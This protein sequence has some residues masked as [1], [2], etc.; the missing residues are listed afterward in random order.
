M[1]NENTKKQFIFD[2]IFAEEI[3]YTCVNDA[4]GGSV[5]EDFSIV[6]GAEYGALV[7]NPDKEAQALEVLFVAVGKAWH[8]AKRRTMKSGN[9]EIVI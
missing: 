1:A 3:K 4:P 2:P 5:P 6:E 9:G 8:E 7:F